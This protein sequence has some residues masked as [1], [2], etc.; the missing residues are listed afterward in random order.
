QDHITQHT[1]GVDFIER[2]GD[3]L[4]DVRVSLGDDEERQT[5]I[6]ILN[7]YNDIYQFSPES[8][9]YGFFDMISVYLEEQVA[10][11]NYP[12]RLIDNAVDQA[13]DMIEKTGVARFPMPEGTDEY[14]VGHNPQTLVVP[15]TDHSDLAFDFLDFYFGSDHYFNRLLGAGP[16]STP[17][18]QELLNDDRMQSHETWDNPLGQE[19]REHLNEFWD[20]DHYYMAQYGRTDPA[21]IYWPALVND[22]AIGMEMSANGYTGRTTPE[23]AVD[24]TVEKLENQLPQ[25]LDGYT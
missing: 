3:S 4:T 10:A 2:T 7:H 22:T 18:T 19:Y 16:N 20:N 17:I 25:V 24:Q 5:A 13:P 23:E 6:D 15:Q 12:G 9:N 11:T 21:S 8:V 14:R 1:L